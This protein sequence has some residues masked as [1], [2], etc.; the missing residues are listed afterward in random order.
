MRHCKTV[1]CTDSSIERRGWNIQFYHSADDSS[2]NS[3]NFAPNSTK[4]TLAGFIKFIITYPL[5]LY[6][7][8][9]IVF[10]MRPS[11]SPKQLKLIISVEESAIKYLRAK[12]IVFCCVN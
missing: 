7:T 9:W 11:P 5:T 8:I 2:E 12:T 4:V 3:Q 1:S 6:N 10:N